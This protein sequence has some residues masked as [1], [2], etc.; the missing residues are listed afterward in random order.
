MGYYANTT[1]KA[2]TGLPP[3]TI[4]LTDKFITRIDRK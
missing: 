4:T 3:Y 1:Y 2:Y